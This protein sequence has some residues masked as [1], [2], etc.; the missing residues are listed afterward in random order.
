VG[1][2]SSPEGTPFLRSIV[3]WALPWL[4]IVA[5]IAVALFVAV[6]MVGDD[7]VRTRGSQGPEVAS[8][9]EPTESPTSEDR[10]AGD[11]PGGQQKKNDEKNDKKKD[12]PRDPTDEPETDLLTKGISVQVLNGSGDAA[13]DDVMADRL[14]RLGYSVVAVSPAVRAYPLTTVFW[15]G[16]GEEAA[17]LLAERFDWRAEPAPGNLSQTV[18]LHVVVGADA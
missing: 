17:R 10:D 7:A 13:A 15:I 18:D 2:H 12:K 11:E 1:K 3:S 4:L 8:S 14:A 9:A 16:S 6:K 5:V